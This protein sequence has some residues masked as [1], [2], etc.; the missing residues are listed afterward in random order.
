MQNTFF[1]Q[2]D[3]I[4]LQ[5]TLREQNKTITTAESCTGGLIA[6]M[7]TRIS[8]S[9]DIFNGAVVTYSNKI[10]NQELNVNNNTLEKY[11]AV[12]KEVVEQMLDGVIIKFDANYAIAVSGIA[13]PSGGSIEKPVGTVVVGISSKSGDKIVLTKHFKG[14]REEIQIHTANY[15]FQEISKF[16]QKTI[17][18]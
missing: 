13:G 5:N 1:T 3:M 16:I 17:D 9:S 14:T 2:K 15:A 7:L 8:G 18:K 10:K 12:S 4:E 6:N 11:G